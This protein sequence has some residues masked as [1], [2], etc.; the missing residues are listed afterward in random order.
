MKNFISIKD[1]KKEEIL[2][3]LEIAK[4]FENQQHTNILSNKVISCVFFENS[5][6]TRL[7]FET[8]IN[9]LGGK[10]IGFATSENTSI[11][12]GET[13]ADTIKMLDKYSDAIVM[14][15]PNDGA[16]RWASFN[17][18]I[19]I[20][21]A[22]DGS[23]Q[24]PSQTLLDLYTILKE[25]KRIT[26]LKV[27]IV[28]DLKYGRTCHSLAMALSMFKNDLIFISPKFLSMPDYVKEHLNKNKTKWSEFEN[29]EDVIKDVDVLYM[30]R[31]Q[32]E[33]FSSADEFDRVKNYFVLKKDHLKKVKNNLIILH[34]LPRVDEIEKDVDDTKYAKYFEQAENGVHVR[35]AMLTIALGLEKEIK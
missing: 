17:S 9:Q 33:R 12:K 14:R 16:A 5:T 28:G 24:H 19:P 18:T 27:A 15:H 7:S 26:G 10:V 1:M 13:L 8:S 2:K 35:K 3:V 25:Q 4:K 29:I 21:N 6:R 23:N 22:G 11:Q 30:T 31:M 20:L 32:K 34:P